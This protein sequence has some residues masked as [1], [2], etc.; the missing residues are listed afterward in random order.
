MVPASSVAGR[1]VDCLRLGL[2]SGMATARLCQSLS[3]SITFTDSRLGRSEA[4][5]A[6]WQGGAQDQGEVLA[7]G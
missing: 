7:E 2:K 5:R 4:G 1:G 3:R 6:A